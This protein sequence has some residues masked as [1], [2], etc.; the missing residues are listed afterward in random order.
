[1]SQEY[2]FSLRSN[3]LTYINEVKSKTPLNTDRLFEIIDLSIKAAKNMICSA[4][5]PFILL[6]DLFDSF[7][8]NEIENIW[9][10]ME[11]RKKELSD[12]FFLP[13]TSTHSKLSFLKACLGL[14]KRASKSEHGELCGRILLYL[15][16]SLP[17][18]EKSGLN[19]SKSFNLSNAT[20]YDDEE[21]AMECLQIVDNDNEIKSNTISET[22]QSEYILLLLL[23]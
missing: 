16:S 2:C 4:D 10:Y 19:L 8:L 12:K 11:S 14:L 21:K 15:S 20:N 1:M 7:D 5:I 13:E 9:L 23:L 3:L 17:L 18:M 6:E 22:P